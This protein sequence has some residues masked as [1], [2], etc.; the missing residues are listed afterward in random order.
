MTLPFSIGS[1]LYNFD[2][3]FNNILVQ[4]NNVT[5]HASSIIPNYF[6]PLECDLIKMITPVIKKYLHYQSN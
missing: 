2:Y 5:S 6:K 4:I 3:L 1:C